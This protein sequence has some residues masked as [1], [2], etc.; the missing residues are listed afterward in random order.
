[1]AQV[2]ARYPDRLI[3]VA[4][5]PTTTEKVVCVLASEIA[6]SLWIPDS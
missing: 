4:L 6:D 2:V 3:G 5:I 1:M